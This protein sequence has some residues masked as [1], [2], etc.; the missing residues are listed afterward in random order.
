MLLGRLPPVSWFLRG[1][2]YRLIFE[3]VR[4][5]LLTLFEALRLQVRYDKL[6]NQAQCRVTLSDDGIDAAHEND[7]VTRAVAF[8]KTTCAHV[9]CAPGRIRTCAPRSGGACSIP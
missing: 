6:D 9:L 5:I 3:V 4:R 7:A 1:T 2:R 8:F